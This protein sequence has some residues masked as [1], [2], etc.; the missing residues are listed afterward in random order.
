MIALP[1]ARAHDQP[2]LPAAT[3]D[4]TICLYKTMKAV[5][6]FREISVYANPPDGALIVYTWRLPALLFDRHVKTSIAIGGP[7]DRGR[8][9][10][11]GTIGAGNNPIDGMK[12]ALA[13]TCHADGGFVDEV[14]LDDGS[15]EIDMSQYVN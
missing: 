6:A 11:S 8:F 9:H 2:V 5:P 7:D 3:R 13:A 10:Y 14:F 1:A 4:V 12:D 15:S